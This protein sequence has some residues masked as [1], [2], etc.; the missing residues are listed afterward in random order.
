[1]H[2]NTQKQTKYPAP[3]SLNV[4]DSDQPPPSP[5]FPLDAKKSM[6]DMDVFPYLTSSDI[7]T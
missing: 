2:F 5:K 7:L 6:V 4:M 1:M 3:W